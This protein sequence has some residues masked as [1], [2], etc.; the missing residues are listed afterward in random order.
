MGSFHWTSFGFVLEAVRG[1][2]GQAD[3]ERSLG[4]GDLRFDLELTFVVEGIF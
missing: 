1:V 2:L 3:D 4:F